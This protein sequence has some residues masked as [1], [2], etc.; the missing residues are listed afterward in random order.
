MMFKS[1]KFLVSIGCLLFT[2]HV[3]SCAQVTPETNYPTKPIRFFVPFSLVSASDI[4]ART[5]GERLVAAWGQPVT[6]ERLKAAGA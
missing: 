2:C 6:V 1:I 4:L 5:I 3:T